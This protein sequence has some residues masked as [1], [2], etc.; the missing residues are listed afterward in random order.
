MHLLTALPAWGSWDSLRGPIRRFGW[1]LAFFY[2]FEKGLAFLAKRYRPT[3]QPVFSNFFRQKSCIDEIIVVHEANTV[4]NHFLTVSLEFIVGWPGGTISQNI[5]ESSQNFMASPGISTISCEIVRISIGG[6]ADSVQAGSWFVLVSGGV[7]F[8]VGTLR[9]S[10]CFPVLLARNSCPLGPASPPI[11]RAGRSLGSVV[12]S[13]PFGLLAYARIKKSVMLWIP[14]NCYADTC[15]WSVIIY[16]LRHSEPQSI[17][18]VV[19]NRRVKC[20][21]D[22]LFNNF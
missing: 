19:V 10:G 9:V 1:P 15:N 14:K 18:I 21:S 8:G 16:N 13:G 22:R 4:G 3:P 17:L 20:P 11:G 7:S 6:E 2:R 12:M 5:L